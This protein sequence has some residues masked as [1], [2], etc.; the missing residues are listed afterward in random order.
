MTPRNT[1][2][3]IPRH[4]V[5]NHDRSIEKEHKILPAMNDDST[6]AAFYDAGE[7]G[8]GTRGAI[9]FVQK[10]IAAG[11][12][13]GEGSMYGSLDV[14][15]VEVDRRAFGLVGRRAWES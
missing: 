4:V 2:R 7:Y 1:L 9:I 15:P 14:G 6:L 8:K 13:F 5:Q 11:G 10:S 12:P 3:A